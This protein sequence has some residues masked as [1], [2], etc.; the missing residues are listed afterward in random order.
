MRDTETEPYLR[1]VVQH[2]DGQEAVYHVRWIK[3]NEPVEIYSD[4]GGVVNLR[5]AVRGV[6]SPSM[7]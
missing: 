5:P 1:I 4:G 6:G 7:T 3:L 2:E